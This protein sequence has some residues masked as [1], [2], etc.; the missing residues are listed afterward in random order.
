M[1]RCQVVKAD[2][3]GITFYPHQTTSVAMA[4]IAV[5][6]GLKRR[7]GA[8]LEGDGDQRVDPR[9]IEGDAILRPPGTRLRK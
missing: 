9:R 4:R 5:L 2:S 3:L 8:M 7:G 1:V 6:G